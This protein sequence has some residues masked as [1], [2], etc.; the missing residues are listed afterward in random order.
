MIARLA[1]LGAAGAEAVAVTPADATS[2]AP[3]SPTAP[4]A[5]RERE[6]LDGVGMGSPYLGRDVGRPRVGRLVPDAP[7]ALEEG[8]P[9]RRC[10][11]LVRPWR[12]R[13]RAIPALQSGRQPPPSLRTMPRH[14]EPYDL[15]VV[16]DWFYLEPD[17]MNE[18]GLG[19]VTDSVVAEAAA[20]GD[21][22]R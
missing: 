15:R 22:R 2:N 20:C 16:V 14:P 4:R 1:A 11:K 19:E 9:T 21:G 8:C 18:R 5:T 3:A 17:G 6:R 13:C 10:P 12:R 7:V